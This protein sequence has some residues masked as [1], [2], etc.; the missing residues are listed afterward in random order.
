M[1]NCSEITIT[2]DC[3]SLYSQFSD[4]IYDG[5]SQGFFFG[6]NRKIQASENE[7][8]IILNSSSQCMYDL[9][10]SSSKPV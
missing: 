6:E 1:T 2:P 5:S 9:S 3:Q 4:P 10:V 7:A 8:I